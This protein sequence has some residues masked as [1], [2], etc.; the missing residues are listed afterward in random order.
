ME[1]LV[2]RLEHRADGRQPVACDA[3][4]VL[5]RMVD[6]QGF[7]FCA[8][9]GPV[10]L[11]G[12]VLAAAQQ[13]GCVLDATSDPSCRFRPVGATASGGGGSSSDSV[14]ELRRSQYRAVAQGVTTEYTM[15]V[16]NKIRHTAELV[17][18][19]QDGPD[20]PLPGRLLSDPRTSRLLVRQLARASPST[21]ARTVA[22]GAPVLAPL[23][24]S[25]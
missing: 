13:N 8:Y 24:V 19:G 25:C 10:G 22:L 17:V 3:R 7:Q 23:S 4:A 11:D 21:H 1:S 6:E 16:A 18:Q 20:P 12:I 5:R 9:N 2:L 15:S 14:S